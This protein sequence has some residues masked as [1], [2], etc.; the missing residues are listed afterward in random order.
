MSVRSLSE[1]GVG[2]EFNYYRV[3]PSGERQKL[4]VS[5]HDAVWAARDA[6][7]A[8]VAARVPEAFRTVL[9]DSIGVREQ[10]PEQDGGRP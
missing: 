8:L 5:S 7:G 6:E 2:L 1:C 10:M 9:L 4:A 3:E